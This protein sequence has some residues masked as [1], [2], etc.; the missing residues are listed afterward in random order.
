MTSAVVFD[1]A[2]ISI[3][4]EEGGFLVIVVIDV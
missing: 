1:Y 2:L 3:Y 4:L